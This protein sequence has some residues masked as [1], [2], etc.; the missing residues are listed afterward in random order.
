[1][2]VSFALPQRRNEYGDRIEPIIE[3]LPEAP[4]GY[5]IAQIDVGRR[6]DP[7]VGLLRFRRSDADELAGLQ[8]AQQP[9]LG[10]VRQLG[11]FVEEDRASVRYF[12]IALAAFRRARER[13]LLVSEKLR[14][15]RPVGNG[16][17]VDR[18]VVAVLA[19][20]VGVDY[21]REKL[22]SYPAFARHED[23][24]IGRSHPQSHLQCPVQ[25]VVVAYDSETLLY[26]G[27]IHGS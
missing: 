7:N 15:D 14:V 26:Y 1:M 21:L 5:G 17:A 4:F 13:S 19:A 8:H 18:D 23:R 9:D 24:Q 12:E 3:V 11:H 27:Q 16:S 20:A 6:D 22:L 25:C 2:D 10:R